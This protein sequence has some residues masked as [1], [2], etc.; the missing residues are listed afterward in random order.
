[1]YMK[2]AFYGTKPYDRIWFEPLGREYDYEIN[3]LETQCTF[4]TVEL[5]K[6][7]DFICVFV[8]DKIDKEIIE[9]LYEFGVKGILLRCAGFNN[10][11]LKAAKGRIKVLRVPSYSPEAVAEHA[12]ALLLSVNRHTHKAYGRTRDFNMSINGLMGVDLHHKVAGVIGT[13]KIGQAMIKMLKGFDM[14]VLAYDPYPNRELD[15]K[16]VEL[17]ELFHKADVISLHCPLTLE[18]Q[19]LINEESIQKMKKGI[20]LINTSRGGLI[21]TSALV[22]GLREGKFRG[23]GLDVYE[24][25]DGVFYEDK[26]NEIILDEVLARLTTFPNVLVT[27]HMGFF[28]REAMQAI[29]IT[30]LKN[31]YAL[32]KGEVLENEIIYN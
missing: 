15:V 4:Q 17:E 13:G 9:R 25:E 28:T 32:E 23:V 21:D 30:T 2:I 22:D 5:A 6:D 27:S 8:N 16:Y 1:M 31:A 20:Y 26:S 7:C 12:M 18:T 19:H 11:D 3:F 24:E 29:A 14:T 10:V